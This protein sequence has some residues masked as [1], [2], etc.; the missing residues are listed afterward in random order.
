M[1]G[2]NLTTPPP[3]SLTFFVSSEALASRSVRNRFTTQTRVNVS[4]IDIYEVK[5]KQMGERH[6]VSEQVKKPESSWPR[7][8]SANQQHGN[9]GEE[10][11]GCQKLK[12]LVATS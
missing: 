2:R 10:K 11:Q 9:G 4:E 8:G 3:S 6:R 5:K 7:E 12:M 1:Y